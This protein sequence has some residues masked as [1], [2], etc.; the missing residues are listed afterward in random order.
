M[1]TLCKFM[2]FYITFLFKIFF[3]HKPTNIHGD[4]NLYGEWK[5]GTHDGDEDGEGGGD[6]LPVSMGTH[7][8]S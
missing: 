4:L 2:I 1:N 6:I 7:C 3:L 8:Y 5:I